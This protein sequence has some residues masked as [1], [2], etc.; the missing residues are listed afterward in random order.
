[1]QKHA[2]ATIA[3]AILST[4]ASPTFASTALAQLSDFQI[5]LIDLNSADAVGPSV[6]FQNLQGGTF[7]AAE[8]G[9]PSNVV[10]DV[11]AGGVPFGPANSTSTHGGGA[12]YSSLSGDPFGAGANATASASTGVSGAYGASTVWLGDGQVYVPF[13]LSADTRLVITANASASALSTLAGPDADTWAS[14]F[15][16]LTDG[17]GQ[18][19]VSQDSVSAE[20]FG[21]TGASPNATIDAHRI[22]ISFENLSSDSMDG[23]FSGSVDAY[24]ADLSP[25]PEPAGMALMLG[26]LGMLAWRGRRRD[27]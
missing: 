10:T 26:G 13:T 27:R 8:S 21:T 25:V 19:G 3:V 6:T 2:V 11:H 14:V 12:A 4:L 16:K 23:I 18:G 24:S 1:M 17:T 22:E 9:T 20:Q 5:Q 15:L 7:V